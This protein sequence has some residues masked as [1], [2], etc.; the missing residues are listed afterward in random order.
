VFGAVHPDTRVARRNLAKT[1]S[2]ARLACPRRE[3]VRP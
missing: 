2:A 1:R 3:A